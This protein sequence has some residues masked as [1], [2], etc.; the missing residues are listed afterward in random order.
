MTRKPSKRADHS[1]PRSKGSRKTA[2]AYGRSLKPISPVVGIGASAGG[3]EALIRLFEAMPS[4]S[5]MAFLVVMHLDPARKSGLTHVLGQ[6]SSMKVAEAADGMAIDP[7]HIYVI[8]PDASLTVDDGRL[9]LTE[10]AERR[11]ARYPIDRLFESLATHRRGSAICIVLSGSGSDGTEGL[12]EVKT[13]GGCILVQDPSTARFDAMPRSAIAAHLADHV[14]APEHMPDVLVRYIRHAYIATSELVEDTPSGDASIDPVLAVLRNRAGHDFRLYK[15]STLTRR[16]QRRMGLCN[17]HTIEEYVEF[18]RSQPGE[19][20]TLAKDLMINVTG[21]FRDPEAWTTLDETVLAQLVDERESGAAVRLWVPA[22]ATGEEAYTL[23]MLLVDR[24]EA[25]NKQFDIKLFATDSQDDNLNA[26]RAGAYSEGAVATI[27]PHLLKRYFDRLDGTYH[28]KKELRDV[29]V[30]AS[31]NLLRD[32]PFSQIDLISCRN[33]LI[34]LNPVAQKRAV[35]LM[36]FALRQGGHLLLGNAESVSGREDLF[37]T[38]SKKWR[39]FRR[40]GPT[41]HDIIDFPLLP[42]RSRPNK[43]EESAVPD[44][45]QPPQRLVDVAQRALLERF[46]P[47]SVLIEG[48]GRVLWFHG[49]TGDYLEPPPGEPSRNLL[50]MARPGLRAKLRQAVRR[51][52]REKRLVDFHVRLRRNDRDQAVAVTVAPLAE[53]TDNLLLVSFRNAEAQILPTASDDGESDMMQRA[54]EDELNTARAEL[55][56]TIEQFERANE[57][58]KAAN[59][60]VT[61]MN[62]ELQSTNEELETSKEELQSFNEELQTVNSQLQHKNQELADTTDTLNNL[63]ASS[64]VA[65]VFLDTDFCIRWF[66]PSS[67]ELLELVDTDVGRP[68]THFAWKVAD[69]ALLRDAET[70]LQKLNGIDAEVRSSADRWY[71]RRVLPYRTQD[72]HIAGVVIAFIDITERKLAL[73]A[74]DEARLYAEAIIETVRHPVMVLDGE[75]RVQSV[76]PAFSEAFACPAKES[77]GYLLQELD[78]GAWDIPKLRRLLRDVLSEA[79]PF[80]GFAIEHDFPGRGRRHMLLNARK[81]AQGVDRAE[82]ILLAIEDV[83]ERVETELVRQTLMNEL[84]HRVKNMLAMVQSIGSQTLRQSGS[85]EEFKVA[86]E[87]RLHSLARVHDLLV[88]ENWH[89]ADL[90]QLVRRTLEPYGMDDRIRIAGPSLNMTPEA[91]VA[92]AMVLNEL[93]TNAVKYGALSNEGGHL[94]VTWQLDSRDGGQWVHLKWTEAGGPPVTPPSR[95]GFGSSL[96]ERSITHQLGGTAT[97]SFSAEGLHCDIAFPWRE[98]TGSPRLKRT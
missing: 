7:D 36:H 3:I 25:A 74:I 19:L 76:N 16:I 44:N 1:E 10:P 65:T 24:A 47:A 5:G 32:P 78:H 68:V 75:L 46:A 86:F 88:A 28:V 54:F 11:G 17:L 21:F 53:P 79:R 37:E 48:D 29:V 67:K 85:L 33:L 63:L 34:Y 30:F 4:D 55:R 51:A 91:G 77:Q 87:G 42:G 82:L 83:T 92:M 69:D 72:D 6:H 70:V 80:E 71:L 39:I 84:S 60:E 12:K 23:A 50:A 38:V 89:R 14:L 8:P 40:L 94:E 15:R 13:Q 22:C 90:D 52:A 41:R 97:Q 98:I 57:E 27:P 45:N 49:S 73:D 31:L 56:D 43:V 9:R 18:L 35:S 20:Q 58:L 81:L 95:R 62:E 26:A 64:E 96:I 2:E 93:T 61:S 59:E 66:S